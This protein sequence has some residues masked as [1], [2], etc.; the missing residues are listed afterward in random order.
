MRNACIK[1]ANHGKDSLK[2]W[3]HATA[4]NLSEVLGLPIHPTADAE[5]PRR[6]ELRIH[7]W[8]NGSGIAPDRRLLFQ[9]IAA[10]DIHARMVPRVADPRGQQ[11][12]GLQRREGRLLDGAE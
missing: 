12:P 6:N 8:D 1:A 3:N 2:K 10:E 7:G 9:Q 5:H 4:S 11:L